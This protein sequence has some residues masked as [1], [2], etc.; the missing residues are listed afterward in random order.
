MRHTSRINHLEKQIES[1]RRAALTLVDARRIFNPD[2]IWPHMREEFFDLQKRC[3]VTEDGVWDTTNLTDKER[4]TLTSFW[5][6]FSP[7][8]PHPLDSHKRRR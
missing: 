4:R 7:I 6:M 3:T 5:G 2:K 1:V 8:G